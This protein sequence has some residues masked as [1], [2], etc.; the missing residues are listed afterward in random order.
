MSFL[1]STKNL[2]NKSAFLFP[3]CVLLLHPVLEVLLLWSKQ[4]HFLKEN[5]FS[6]FCNHHINNFILKLQRWFQFGYFNL[7]NISGFH[8]YYISKNKV[9]WMS[10]Q[11]HYI[12]LFKK[13]LIDVQSCWL[14]MVRIL[15]NLIPTK[16]HRLIWHSKRIIFLS[17]KLL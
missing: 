10:L 8:V 1:K 6:I 7:L 9:E 4:S 3:V 5:T 17:S 14:K 16:D 11:V 15:T 12:G 2:W 13:D